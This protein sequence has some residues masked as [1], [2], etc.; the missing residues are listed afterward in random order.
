MTDYYS[1]LSVQ[2]SAT[3]DE[4]KRAYRKLAMKWHPDKNPDKK[5][6]AAE[7]FQLIAEAYDVL[8]DREKRAIYDQ[9]GEEGLKNG[10]PDGNGGTRGGYSFN[11]NAKEIFERFFG[12]DNPFAEFGFGDSMP[13]KSN[14]KKQGP[15]KA[16]DVTENLECTLEELYNGC[17][18]RRNITHKRFAENGQLENELKL[19]TINV[20]P[21]WKKGTKITFP[22][23]GDEGNDMIPADV[24]FV[25]K[26]KAHK[27]FVREGNNL[28]FTANITLAQALTDCSVPVPTLDGRT[29]SIACNEVISPGYQKLVEGEGMPHS[30]NFKVRGDLLIRFKI[31]FPEYLSDAKKVE[32]KKLLS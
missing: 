20:K 26:E 27:S 28:I 21:G 29:L 1:I 23:E 5:E 17:V 22:N 9:Y 18:K 12:T 11:N 10:I 2:R 14:M 4:L 16:P 13:F 30:K 7:Q 8:S 24:V 6:E 3:D 19:L 31:K 32:L 25:L 15:Q